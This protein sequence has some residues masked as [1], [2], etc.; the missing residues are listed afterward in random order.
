MKHLRTI[1][2]LVSALATLACP[3]TLDLYLHSCRLGPGEG[4]RFGT[5]VEHIYN[6]YNNVFDF[7]RSHRLELHLFGDQT[8]FEWFGDSI[9]GPQGMPTGWHHDGVVAVYKEDRYLST[10]FREVSHL[11]VGKATRYCPLWLDEGLAEVFKDVSIHK[12]KMVLLRSPSTE[13]TLRY[14]LREGLLPPLDEYVATTAAEWR[15]LAIGGHKEAGYEISRSFVAFLLAWPEREQ[16]LR[17][18]MQTLSQRRDR[19]SAVAFASFWDNDLTA[20]ERDWH[21]F[22]RR[23]QPEHTPLPVPPSVAVFERCDAHVHRPWPMKRRPQPRVDTAD[24]VNAAARRPDDEPVDT[25]HQDSVGSAQQMAQ[26]VDVRE[27][28]SADFSKPVSDSATLAPHDSIAAPP[29]KATIVDTLT[30]ML[31]TLVGET[32]ARF[33]SL[34]ARDSV[35]LA[36]WVDTLG[37]T[38]LGR[39]NDTAWWRFT[40]SDTAQ[41]PRLRSAVLDTTVARPHM[42]EV[43]CDLV[44]EADTRRALLYA[45]GITKVLSGRRTTETVK[46]MITAQRRRIAEIYDARLAQKPGLTG[47]VTVAFTVD[48]DGRVTEAGIESSTVGDQPLEDE[49]LQFVRSLTFGPVAAPGN[50]TRVKFPFVFVE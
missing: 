17:R 3:C 48:E 2:Q 9:R 39:V 21:D 31:D 37:R 30:P 1:A 19:D 26:A 43:P 14:W 22:I 29:A 50:V 12:G 38:S 35:R 18:Y 6:Y 20:L 5:T 46:Q 45:E 44:R 10:V 34:L 8:Q 33:A 13:R 25:L 28:D 49:L 23:N 24:T 4:E 41:G 11:L 32:V 36:L 40:G 27:D 42:M 47:N 15:R 16:K 7:R